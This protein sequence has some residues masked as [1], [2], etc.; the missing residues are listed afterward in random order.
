MAA[1]SLIPLRIFPASPRVDA[2]ERV[3]R[4]AEGLE[5][6]RPVFAGEWEWQVLYEAAGISEA[7]AMCAA[8]LD[9]LD[10]GWEEIL[11]FEAVPAFSW[12]GRHPG[13]PIS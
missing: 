5:P 7:M 12:S 4:V 6:H 3:A 8:D 10:P 13:R 2:R 1:G 11:D 9:D